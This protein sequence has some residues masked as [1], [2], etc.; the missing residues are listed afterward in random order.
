M[1]KY[2]ISLAALLQIYKSKW[3]FI[4]IFTAACCVAVVIYSFI[5]P[6]TYQSTASLFPP[7]KSEG[8]GLSSFLQSM[9]GGGLSIGGLGQNNQSQLFMEVLRSKSAAM[10]VI[11]KAKLDK[12][13]EFQGMSEE[14]LVTMVRSLI[15]VNVERTGLVSIDSYFDTGYFPNTESKLKAAV[16]AANI[17]NYA[18]EALDSLVRER[19]TSGARKSREYIERELVNYRFK[20]DSVERKLEAFQKTN[21]VLKIEEQTEALVNQSIELGLELAKAETELKMARQE[22]ASNSSIVKQI[23]AKASNLRAQYAQS[24]RGG[25]GDDNFTLPFGN[26][27]A[28]AREY[29]DLFRDRK[30]Y[31]QVIIY[32]ET[33]RHQEAISESRD[34]PVVETL[35]KALATETQASPNKRMMLLLGFML[36]LVCALSIVTWQAIR[37]GLAIEE[38]A[39]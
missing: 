30:I 17:A 35:D 23:E 21:K 15:V 14:K 34:V 1:K 9:S 13:P 39:V 16:M 36:S 19:S 27:P 29:A 25:S 32:L 20:L 28:L 3:K 37:A 5:I 6:Q 33:Q 12:M 22:Y 4:S 31:E 18:I 2:E 26:I 38:K 8:G 7:N 11:K 24:Q 10:Y